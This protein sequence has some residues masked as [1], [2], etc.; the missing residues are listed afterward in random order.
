M[1]CISQY[2]Q[3]LDPKSKHYTIYIPLL[4]PP[5][6]SL[7]SKRIPTTRN[8]NWG[9]LLRVLTHLV[10]STWECP[11]DLHSCC[12]SVFECD[13]SGCVCRG[14][15]GV[16]AGRFGYVFVTKRPLGFKIITLFTSLIAQTGHPIGLC[17]MTRFQF[18][19]LLSKSIA[20]ARQ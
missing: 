20:V 4:P 15:G 6:P 12:T 17:L 19:C 14:C 8:P 10:L 3:H 2:C 9:V 1:P 7:V 16:Q 5:S 13:L 11:S 18:A